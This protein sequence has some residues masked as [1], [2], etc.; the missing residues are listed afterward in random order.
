MPDLTFQ[1]AVRLFD[2]FGHGVETGGQLAQLVLGLMVDPHLEVAAT[3]AL[4]CVHQLLEGRD[5][6]VLQLV[7]PDQ[8][9][10]H[11]GEQ[12]HALDRL[13]PALLLFT[14]TLQQIDELVQLLNEG[15]SLD[16]KGCRITA[17]KCRA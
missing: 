17:L 16:L 10:N 9:D 14:L 5:D 7:Q 4:G 11:G 2:R 3:K 12:G 8:Q 13:L 6:T 1:S 15:M